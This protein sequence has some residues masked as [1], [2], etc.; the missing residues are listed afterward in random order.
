MGGKGRIWA[1]KD[2]QVGELEQVFL[3]EYQHAI[4]DKGRLT[5][6]AKFRRPLLDGLVVTRGL[7]RNLVIY[8]MDEWGRLVERV[9]QLPY[10]DPEARKFRRLVFS[11]ANDVELDKQGRVNIPTYLLEFARISKEV[12]VVG[13]HGYV[14]LWSPDQW[15]A[16]RE[17]LENE[18]N[19]DQWTNLGI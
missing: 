3:G 1:G 8:P 16:V 17:A 11:G 2:R 15:L 12:V 13:V 4:D 6:P 19:T 5:I 18:E 9:N 10:G 7:D 14:E